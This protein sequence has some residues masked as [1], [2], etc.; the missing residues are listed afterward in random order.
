MNWNSIEIKKGAKILQGIGT[1]PYVY[2]VHSYY[3]RGG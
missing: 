3:L 1:N 2:F